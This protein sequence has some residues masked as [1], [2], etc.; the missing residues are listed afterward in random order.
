ML[1][2]HGAPLHGLSRAGS[3]RL[4]P[5]IAED[6]TTKATPVSYRG[7]GTLLREVDETERAFIQGLVMVFGHQGKKIGNILIKSSSRDTNFSKNPGFQK[8]LPLWHQFSIFRPYNFVPQRR[9][10]ICLPRSSYSEY[11]RLSSSSRD[12]SSLSH[13]D[14]IPS[15]FSQSAVVAAAGREGNKFSQ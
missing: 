4:V 15:L 2:L 1:A 12:D 14:T 10:D 11:G 8:Y 3:G 9:A 7:S 5:P 13:S 6:V